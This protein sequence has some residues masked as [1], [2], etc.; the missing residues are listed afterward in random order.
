M[1]LKLKILGKCLVM[2]EHRLILAKPSGVTLKQHHFN[3]ATEGAL[4]I[5][6]LPATCL[7]YKRKTGN[8]FAD[9][10]K[11]AC[12]HHDDGKL[13][14]KWQN[15][16][17]ADY[18]DFITWQNNS[19][20]SFVEYAKEKKDECGRHIMR[21]GVRH[22]LK[23]IVYDK[24]K[25]QPLLSPI[26]QVAIAA[27]HG[28]LCID[29]KERWINE[30][31]EKLWNIIEHLSYSVNEQR[32]LKYIANKQYQYSGIR[33]VL[34]LA[35]HR[36]SGKELDSFVPQYQRFNYAFPYSNKRAIQRLVEENWNNDL[37]LVRAPTGAGK[38]DASLLWASLQ[39]NNKRADRVVIAMPT[40][41]TSNALAISVNESL[42]ETGLYHSS[43][44]FS[45]FQNR[46]ETGEMQKAE[47][48][49]MHESARLLQTPVTV[50]TIDHLLTALTLTREEHH[51]V[52]FNLANSCLVIDE[53]DFYDEFT[54]SNILVL[55]KLL[56]YWDVPVLLMSASL[57][58]CAI[59]D[60]K[61]IG[62]SIEKIL[63]DKSDLER[64]RFSVED[65]IDYS[66]VCDIEYLLYKMIEQKNGIIYANTVDKAVTFYMWFKD[67]CDKSIPLSLYHSRFTEPDKMLKEQEILSMLGKKSW[68][69]GSAC[70]IVILTQIGEMSIN[71]SAEIMISELC[72]VD[73]LIQRAGRLCRF[74]EKV[75]KL[76]ILNPFKKQQLYPAPYGVYDNLT[77]RWIPCDAIVKTKDLLKCKKYN[78]NDII[79]LLNSVYNK[80]YDYSWKAIENA[81]LLEVHFASNWLV[82]PALKMN[83]DDVETN[84][85][86]SRD[87]VEQEIVFVSKPETMYFVSYMDFQ[88]WKLSN[89]IELPLYLVREGLVEHIIDLLELQ[90]KD[91]VEHCYV[92][93]EGFYRSDIGVIFKKDDSFII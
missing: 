79:G 93:R 42:S 9:L 35:D 30:G 77:K 32:N 6:T 68:E 47:A 92:I 29:Q 91:K 56:K 15:A 71:I 64:D 8:D 88:R 18:N 40:R 16:C 72:P 69:N 13:C 75:G 19:A 57:P 23:S 55:L 86:K 1:V 84:I 46:V 78:F 11:I 63:E 12:E 36:A 54:Q 4:I 61:S 27:H 21:A 53:A 39:I 85:W 76:Y 26:L 90:V 7:K 3:V 10:L 62:Y 41:F 28:K 65:I 31:E 25:K 49:I 37:L 2:S 52:T 60:Y 70:G 20:K 43:A 74:N 34:Q 87:I 22:E 44:W 80:G 38:T 45:W 66:D 82:L 14:K 83:V 17:L 51:L 58:E 50:C 73:R 59:N 89:S 33:G 81:R 5:E 67:H 24:K 48:E